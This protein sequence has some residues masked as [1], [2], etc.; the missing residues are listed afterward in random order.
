[1]ALCSGNARADEPPCVFNA[2]A[3]SAATYRHRPGV[4]FVQWNEPRASAAIVTRSGRAVSIRH[5]RCQHLGAEARVVIDGGALSLEI[6]AA[7]AELADIALQPRVAQRVRP[8]IAAHAFD[9]GHADRLDLPPG[10]DEEFY[11]ASEPVG[12]ALLL[13]LRYYRD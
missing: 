10:G 12:T 4:V 11:V 3:F 1:M 8:L 6:E 9:P 2:H 7:L 5:W 13:T